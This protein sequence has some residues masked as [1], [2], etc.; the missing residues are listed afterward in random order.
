MFSAL[1]LC[2]CVDAGQANVLQACLRSQQIVL[3]AAKVH[4]DPV[5]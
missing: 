1:G 3:S 4:D 2:V 5:Q